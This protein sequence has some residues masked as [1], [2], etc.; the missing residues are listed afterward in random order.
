MNAIRSCKIVR[1][2]VLLSIASLSS[3][4]EGTWTRKADMPTARFGLSTGVVN[5]KVYAIGGG[6]TAY[7]AYLSTVE[8]YDP[9]TDTWTKKADM[10]TARNGHAASVVNGKIYVVGGEPSAQA[11]IPTVEEY[12]PAMDAWT[13]KADMPTRRTFLCASAVNG[14]VYAIGGVIAGPPAHPDPYTGAVEEYDPATDIW[15]KKADM[16]TQRSCF[17]TCVLDGKIYVIGGETGNIHSPPISTMEEYDPSTD[18]WTRKANM[19]TARSFLS[20]IAVG[21]KIYAIGGVGGGTWPGTAFSTVEKYDP[22]TDTWTTQQDMPTARIMLSTSAVDSKIYAIGGTV[23]VSA[24]VWAGISTVEEH[25]LTPAAPDFNGDG[26]IDGKDVLIMA[27]CWGQDDPICDIAPAPF[28]D[29][30]VDVEDLMVLAEYIGS[31]VEDRTLIT[32]W[33]LDEVDGIT[34]CDS[35]GSCDATLCG[36]PLWQ[37]DGG[38]VHGAVALD[39][40]DDFLATDLVLN[41]SEGPFSILA[42]VKGGMPDQEIVSQIDGANWLGADPTGGFLMTELRGLG[43]DSRI[44]CSET[45]ITD[46]NWHRIGLTWDGTSRRVYADDMVVAEDTQAGGPPS[47]S[48]G[49]NIGCGKDMTPGTFFS[50]LI[51]EIRIYNRALRP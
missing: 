14:R 13:R 4:V 11:S 29:G 8:E 21:G 51:D 10:S 15:T 9:T 6:K 27:D 44:L 2:T 40:I 38:A 31:N 34:A 1:V 46:G 41:P 30:L 23:G 24:D 25:D 36:D 3:A 47:C 22:T 49:L 32:H 39:G 12:D 7:G 28:G 5:G 43:R 17:S 45:I 48:G 35:A 33:K 42:W 18:T 20:T 37:P 19:P 16:P 50:G 26:R